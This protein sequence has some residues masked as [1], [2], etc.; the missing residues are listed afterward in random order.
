MQL[1]F[2]IIYSVKKY[3]YILSKLRCDYSLKHCFSWPVRFV[4][5][6]LNSNCFIPTC[7]TVNFNCYSW[8]LVERA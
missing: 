8:W 7:I 4:Y 6:S 1:K 3:Y 2:P 5:F